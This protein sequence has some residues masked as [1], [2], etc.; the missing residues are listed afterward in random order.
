NILRGPAGRRAVGAVP[1]PPL[2]DIREYGVGDRGRDGP[3]MRSW[4]GGDDRPDQG[5]SR[6]AV[7]HLGQELAHEE[8]PLARAANALA[9][10]GS[11]GA[12]APL[13]I[14]IPDRPRTDV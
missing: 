13:G 11:E 1:R 8:E 3:G 5:A 4:R 14:S 10:I 7:R 2:A 6:V 12:A 9:R